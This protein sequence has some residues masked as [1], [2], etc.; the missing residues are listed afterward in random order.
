MYEYLDNYDVDEAS[1]SIR[2]LEAP[3]YNHELVKRALVMGCDRTEED[4][5]SISIL[6]N[7]LVKIG[8]MTYDQLLSGFQRWDEREKQKS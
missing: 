2:L 5:V 4:Q 1:L 8:L 3:R 6:F 7:Y